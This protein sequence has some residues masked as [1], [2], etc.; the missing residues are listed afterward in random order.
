[1]LAEQ[2]ALTTTSHGA[3]GRQIGSLHVGRAWTLAGLAPVRLLLPPSGP[4][5]FDALVDGMTDRLTGLGLPHT[6]ETAALLVSELIT[7]AVLHAGTPVR[8]LVFRYDGVLRVEVSDDDPT[9]PRLVDPDPMR[10]GGRG[11]K[12]VDALSQRWGA[13]AGERGKTICS[14]YTG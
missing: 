11:I 14:P 2:E 9:L 8:L 1:M 3:A 5:E 10:P 12:L 6:V 7:N 4:V 13:D